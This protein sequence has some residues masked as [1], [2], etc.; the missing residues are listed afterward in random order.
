MADAFRVLLL[1]L[2][3]AGMELP[4][5]LRSSILKSQC[6]YICPANLLDVV[7][8]LVRSFS[9]Y[10]WFR[11]RISR[12]IITLGFDRKRFLG[13]PLMILQAVSGPA[14]LFLG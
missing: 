5:T 8:G 11:F 9:E 6:I 3:T 7:I 10:R 14:L 1:F 4:A 2:T 12:N 13:Q